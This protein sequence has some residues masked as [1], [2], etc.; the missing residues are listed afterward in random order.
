MAGCILTGRMKENARGLSRRHW[1][2]GRPLNGLKGGNENRFSDRVFA[3]LVV[4]CKI[5]SEYNPFVYV[6]KCVRK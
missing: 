3:V 5:P 1:R 2:T 4:G 6:G